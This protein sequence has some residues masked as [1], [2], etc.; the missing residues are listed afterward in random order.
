MNLCGNKNKYEEIISWVK[1]NTINYNSKLSFDD[2]LFITG[3]SGIGKTYSIKQICKELNLYV[4][5]IS[6]NNCSNSS[7]LIDHITKAST[8]SLMQ[9][10]M[11]NKDPKIMIIDDFDSIITIDR[12]VNSSFVSFLS[13]MKIKRIPIICISSIE[14]MRRIG[15]IKNKCKIIELVDPDEND[16][17]NTLKKLFPNSS[18]LRNVIKNNGNLSQCIKQIEYSETEFFDNMDD[19]INVNILYGNDFNRKNITKTVL[20]DPWVIPLRFHENIIIELKN[21][22]IT[23]SKCHNLYKS[24]LLNFILYDVLMYKTNSSDL[25]VD[26]FTSII[27]D[28]LR[29]DNKKNKRANIANFTKILSFISLQKKN[30]KRAYTTN[31]P[32]YQI[33]NYHINNTRNFI[34]F[35]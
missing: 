25:V 2:V 19:L 6:S 32:L 7:D 17:F 10:L 29:I 31:F 18:N 28:F 3:N 12:T 26:F 8:S 14:I 1:S 4:N 24:F 15:S 23:I 33:N 9:T 11:N 13:S 35:N 30:I 16:L 5:Y 22:K 34:S 21:R 20:T 27:H